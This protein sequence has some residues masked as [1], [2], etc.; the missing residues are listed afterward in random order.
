MVL[1]HVKTIYLRRPLSALVAHLKIKPG[2]C[3][4]VGFRASD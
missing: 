1:P 3:L 4:E 2:P